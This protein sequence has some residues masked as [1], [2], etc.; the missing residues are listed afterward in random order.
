MNKDSETKK[1]VKTFCSD[2]RDDIPEEKLK[3]NYDRQFVDHVP[4]S[5]GSDKRST[6]P[7]LRAAATFG[8]PKDDFL[9][10]IKSV[11]GIS[12]DVELT[13]VMMDGSDVVVDVE[14]NF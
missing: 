4:V 13:S 5:C 7:K 10:L 11:F 12:K 8:I 3:Q 14:Y 1:H 2:C 9:K 6:T